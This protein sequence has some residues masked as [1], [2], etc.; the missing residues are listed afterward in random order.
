MEGTHGREATEHH[1]VRL[2]PPRERGVVRRVQIGAHQNR[3]RPHETLRVPQ[4]QA[5]HE[6]KRQRGLDR[7]TREVLLPAGA[8]GGRRSPGVNGGGGEPERHVASL[9]E[10][11]R[12]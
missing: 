11:T 2:T 6:A 9:N 7:Q 10:R 4:R 8:T 3:H 5:E 12:V 1:G